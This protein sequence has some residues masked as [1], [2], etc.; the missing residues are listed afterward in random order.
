LR[1]FQILLQTSSTASDSVFTESLLRDEELDKAF[2]VRGF[3]FE[4]T[5]WVVGWSDIG[6]EEEFAGVGVGPVFWDLKLGLSCLNGFD[7]FLEGAVLAD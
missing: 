5:V 6:V 1:G 4:V 3:P 7:E 2:D